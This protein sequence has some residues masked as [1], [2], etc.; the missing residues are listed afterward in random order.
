MVDSYVIDNLKDKLV[1]SLQVLDYQFL[2]DS[3]VVEINQQKNNFGDY[4]SPIA[5]QIAKAHKKNP[6]D[7]AQQIVNNIAKDDLISEINILGPG[8]INFNINNNF[9][10]NILKQIIAQRE[11][12]AKLPHNKIRYNV[13]Y[14][15]ANP[16]GL[17]HLGHARNAALGSTFSNILIHRGYEVTQEYYINDAGNQINILSNSIYVRY[18][19]ICGANMEMPEDCY[20]G[21][22]IAKAAQTF[23]NEH[24]AKY[25]QK[26]LDVQLS[27][28]IKQ[29]GIQF[30]L[31]EI[32]TDLKN[33]GVFMDVWFSENS[34]Y[35]SG[36]ILNVLKKLKASNSS[37]VK[38]GA[39]WLKSTKYNDDK[40][41]VIVKSDGSYTYLLPD[42]A[43]HN[44][45]FQKSDYVVNVWGADHYG[46]IQRMKAALS[47]LG[48]AG[49]QLDILPTQMVRVV[50]DGKEQKMSKRAGTSITLRELLNV[51][52]KDA[53]RY[54]MVSRTSESHLD[55]DM[56]LV[57]TKSQENPLFYLQYAHA[58][59]NQIINSKVDFEVS[60]EINLLTE[61][62]EKELMIAL[63]E[64]NLVLKKIVDKKQP[65]L[66]ANYLQKLAKIF[67]SYYNEHKIINNENEQLTNQRLTLVLCVKTILF[68]GLK[69]MGVNAPNKM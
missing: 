18:Q 38:D 20:R 15:S 51:I 49:E 60:Q 65:H 25:Y 59:I 68:N 10:I 1:K 2:A 48:H 26:P 39:V 56:K 47:C 37:Y 57:T 30:M 11:D 35:Q 8:F 27:D 7:I 45:K 50:K 62:K 23:Y 42:I 69:L 61:S 64:Y 9:F 53:L 32:K 3:I 55:I 31:E 22:E 33:Y 63:D 6:K 41:R 24:G 43:Y 21:E 28:F 29:F 54:F 17:L 14:V 12:Y 4:S 13:E 36:A 16:T 52:G 40:D 5:L 19:N 34:L 67:H 66:L 44:I 58:R 46:Y